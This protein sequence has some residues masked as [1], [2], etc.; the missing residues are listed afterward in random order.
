M[1]QALGPAWHGSCASLADVFENEGGNM[2]RITRA[3]APFALAASLGA[4]AAAPDTD[5]VEYY[6][7]VLN[8]YFVTATA[9]EAQ[10]IESGAAGPGWLRTG[11]SFAAWID[12]AR[13]PADAL[14]V[15]RFY[16][17]GANSHFYTAGADECA[18][19]RQ[20]E[21]QERARGGAVLGWQYEGVAFYVQAPSQGQCP[22]GTIA[23]NRVYN[24]GLATGEGSNHRFVDDASLQALM[25]DR[26]WIAEGAVMCPQPKAATG[27]NAN[28]AATATRFESLA[29]T[30]TGTATWKS[31]DNGTEARS[32][33]ALTLTFDANGAVTGSGN[34]CTFAGQV[35]AGDGFRS[36]FTGSITAAGCAASA[37]NGDYRFVHLERFGAGT[38]IVRMKREAGPVEARIDAELTTGTAVAPPAPG[39]GFS[40]VAGDWT[41]TVAW[42]AGSGGKDSGGDDSRNAVNR[43]LALSITSAGALT[44]NGN[45]CTLAGTLSATKSGESAFGGTVDAAGCDNAAFDGTYTGVRV[46]RED[47]GRIEI[48]FSRRAQGMQAEIEGS[49]DAAGSTAPPQ[50]PTVPDD[51]L[52]TGSWEGNVTFLATV[53]TTGGHVTAVQ[54]DRQ[55]LQLAIGDDGAVTGSGFGCTFAGQVTFGD[56]K[57]HVSGGTITAAGC[58]NAV[59]NGT[60]DAIEM[61]REDGRALEIQVR[62]ENEVAGTVKIF[63]AL[64]RA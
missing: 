59:F 23:V 39:A 18:L 38:L 34:G 3:F 37:F 43:P 30:W 2:Q 12:K 47:G 49:L 51:G 27:T 26:A 1:N 19:L 33:D 57:R 22:A 45:G 9:S 20:L 52:V 17:S 56:G 42:I 7:A 24:N 8:H 36:H 60:Y 61:Q 31:E 25:V 32:Q 14:P 29:A 21:A 16:S 44:G 4:H 46:K 50:P 54:I 41:G 62:R 55:E 53:R 15:C 48:D 6:N 35:S 58:T 63:G 10:S 64:V 5:V 28:L 40:S 11:R 13:A